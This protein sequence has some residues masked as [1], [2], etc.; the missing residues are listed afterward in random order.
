M[1]AVDLAARIRRLVRIPSSSLADLLSDGEAAWGAHEE[2]TARLYEALHYQL[3]LRWNELTTDDDD[4][5]AIQRERARAKRAGIRP[6]QTPLIPPNALRPAKLAQQRVDQY[7]A[8]A[9]AY[10]LGEQQQPQMIS[11]AEFE[12]A[13][14]IVTEHQ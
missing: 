14:G 10:S 6:P 13:K 2:N 11:L 12:R 5:A 4:R 9:Q 8:E 7:L 1:P 3:Q